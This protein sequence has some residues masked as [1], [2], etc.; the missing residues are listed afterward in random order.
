MTSM[1]DQARL[2]QGLNPL[3]TAL[4]VYNNQLTTPMSAMSMASSHMTVQT[5]ASSIQPYNPQEWGLTPVAGAERA[6][7]QYA[8]EPQG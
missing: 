8:G 5:P 3:T 2:R 7:R 4:G 6:A 1:R